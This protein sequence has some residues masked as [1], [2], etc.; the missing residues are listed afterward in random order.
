MLAFHWAA[1]PTGRTGTDQARRLESSLGAG[2]PWATASE[3]S[4]G[5]AYAWC[6]IG[7]RR[8]LGNWGPARTR[9]GC[10][11]LFNGHLDAPEEL[12]RVLG[13]SSA[14][15]P[16]N[17]YGEAV[18]RWGD[19]AEK[20]I[21][22]QY[23]AIVFDP[24][25]GRVRLTRSPLRAPPLH[26]QLSDGAVVAASVVRVLFAMGLAPR[27]DEQRLIDAGYG[28]HGEESRSWYLDAARV[29]L[30]SVV[31]IVRAAAALRRTYEPRSIP[32]VRLARN[33]DYV[34]RAGALLREGTSAA[35]RGFSRPGATLSGG[36]DSPTVVAAALDVLPAAKRLPT[37]TFHP[38]AEFEDRSPPGMIGNERPM[39][40]AFAAMHPR[41]EPH[42]IDNRGAAFDARCRELFHVTG[43]APAGLSNM[44][45]FHGIYGA[46]Q[47]AGCDA[48]LLAEWGNESF[49]QKGEWAFVEYLRRGRWRQLYRALRDH[50]ADPRPLLRKFVAL[51]LVPLLSDPAWRAMKRV[52][53]RGERDILEVIS[54][55]T[56]EFIASSRL[57]ERAA[58][59]RFNAARFQPRSR[60]D[61]IRYLFANG[62]SEAAEIHQGF[63]QL[64]GVRQRDPASYRPLVEFCLGIPT[65]Q[66]MR[67]GQERWLAKRM[68]AGLIP[69]AQ[70]RNLL[71][72][73]HDADWAVRL[74]PRRDALIAE[75][76]RIAADPRFAGRIDAPRFVAALKRWNG[77]G[78][79]CDEIDRAE[80]QIAAPRA[81]ML[82]RF[83]N[84][85][86]GRNDL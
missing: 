34:A 50:R 5:A 49:S 33:E 52:V 14:E 51:S 20:R 57:G 74:A 73:F 24:A 26:Y 18:E 7:R 85:V 47:A 65:D 67:D 78:R 80:I 21:C 19:D 42:F 35:L 63:E 38:L 25:N 58:Q 6:E 1:T 16:A 70:R 86:E 71:N 62:D 23:A 61:N 8:I 32:D 82:T 54:P 10:R 27:L 40:E 68:A 56:R 9:S 59:A 76:E 79:G 31:E 37:F 15:T 77:S 43:M 64:Y 60:A 46:A 48:L 4:D 55:F 22:G 75:F 39:V 36:L 13:L 84:F 29:P 66:F 45:M 53:H 3:A 17:L 28:L 69:E 81:L 11:V 41:L 83:V 2:L 12:S 30:G 72:G 44:Y